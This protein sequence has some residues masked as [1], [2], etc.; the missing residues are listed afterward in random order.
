M[1][2]EQYKALAEKERNQV[3]ITEIKA[4]KLKEHSIQSIIRVKTSAGIEGIGVY[5]L[6]AAEKAAQIIRFLAGR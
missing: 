6:D 1:T 3:K 2:T 5:D 4:Y